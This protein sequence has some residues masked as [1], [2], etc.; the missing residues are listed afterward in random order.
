MAEFV[1]GMERS[2]RE[3]LDYLSESFQGTCS[4]NQDDERGGKGQSSGTSAG[5]LAQGCSTNAS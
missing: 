3:L 1:H 2:C 4:R 5:G